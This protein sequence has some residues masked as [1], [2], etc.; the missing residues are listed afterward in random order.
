M[1]YRLLGRSAT[2]LRV[3]TEGSAGA[4]RASGQRSAPSLA[5]PSTH[6]RRSACLRLYPR[7]EPLI[8]DI[9]LCRVALVSESVRKTPP[10]ETAE[11]QLPG[12]ITV[13]GRLKN[14]V[15]R[16]DD[17]P[18]TE[19]S[20][21]TSA[22]EIRSRTRP[23]GVPRGRPGAGVS[24]SFT[25]ANG[26]VPRPVEAMTMVTVRVVLEQAGAEGG[27]ARPTHGDSETC[28]ALGANSSRATHGTTRT[29]LRTGGW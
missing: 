14:V 24:R 27:R 21:A 8:R 9:A 2:R 16:P 22:A 6:R 11:R 18:A 4:R 23:R 20:A 17:A 12:S 13:H 26:P 19:V 15:A 5:R 7:P 10:E 25:A 1:R 3:E 29:P 28:G